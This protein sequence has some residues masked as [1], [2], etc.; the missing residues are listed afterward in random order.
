MAQATTQRITHQTEDLTGAHGMSIKT[1][2]T[3]YI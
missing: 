1:G 3:V 2:H